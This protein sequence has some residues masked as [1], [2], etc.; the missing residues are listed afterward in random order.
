MYY[1]FILYGLHDTKY[2]VQLSI[3]GPVSKPPRPGTGPPP[4]VWVTLA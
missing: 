4:I 3:R 1:I 2:K